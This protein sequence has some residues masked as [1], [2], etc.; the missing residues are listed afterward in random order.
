MPRKSQQGRFHPFSF[1]LIAIVLVASVFLLS[2]A[3]IVGGSH[4]FAQIALTF[5]ILIF[6]GLVFQVST[7]SRVPLED[8]LLVPEP[9]LPGTAGRA[10]PA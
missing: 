10:P 7:N 9:S 6:L 8:F 2:F 5:P 1:S 4:G 3:L